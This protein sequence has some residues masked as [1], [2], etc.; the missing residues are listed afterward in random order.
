LKWVY[1]YVI[2]VIQI[3]SIKMS[4]IRECQDCK[5][6]FKL[7]CVVEKYQNKNIDIPLYCPCC[8][9]ENIAVV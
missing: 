3:G 8:G 7:S 9:S 6:R 5:K 1:G 2:N 4:K